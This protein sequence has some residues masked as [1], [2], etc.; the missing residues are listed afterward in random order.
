[1][2]Y[3]QRTEELEV[4]ETKR[5]KDIFM[6]DPRNIE[7]QEGFN[8]R[9]VFDPIVMAE[10][11]A[12]IKA[13][14][15][16]VPILAKRIKGDTFSLVNGERRLRACMELIEEGHPIRIP[17]TLFTGSEI[18]AVIDMLIT[19]QNVALTAL[20][21]ADVLSRL[22]RMGLTDK[23]IEVKTGR[24]V[25]IISNMRILHAVPEHIKNM[26]V[27]E[28][29]SSTL[30]TQVMREHKDDMA[31]GIQALENASTEVKTIVEAG[32]KPKK[33]T[34][35]TL[36]KHTGKYNSAREMKKIVKDAKGRKLNPENEELFNFLKKI[37]GDKVSY[38][39]ME[40]LFFLDQE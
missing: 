6:V 3:T 25:T 24:S 27:E 34:A 22:S 7:V 39:T 1:M 13:N 28:Q 12:S 32:G 38:K 8:G 18:E 29:I 31:A 37:A 33:V 23:E 5:G 36:E 15:V 4:L 11:K 30:V 10:L 21:E 9:K 20:E 40:K 14:G 26:I 2:S 19:N 17:T 35:K 16:R